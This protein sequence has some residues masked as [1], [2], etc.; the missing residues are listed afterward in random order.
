LKRQFYTRH[1]VEEY[2]EYDPDSGTLEVWQRAGDFLHLAPFAGEWRSPRLGVTL[3]VEADGA[4][5]VYGP[6]GRRFEKP[7]D[8]LNRADVEVAKAKA[9]AADA[10]AEAA[11]LAAKLRELG[12]E[13]E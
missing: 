9:E 1:G 2:Y 10:K 5:G 3:K 6:D 4:L 7:K 13:P 11:R 12:V 8:A